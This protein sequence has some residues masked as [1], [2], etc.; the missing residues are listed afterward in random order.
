MLTTPRSVAS[1]IG[2][3][4]Q[5][6]S[7]VS[8]CIVDVGS[9]MMSNWLQLNTLKPELVDSTR[10][11]TTR[12][13][14]AWIPFNLS[15]LFGIHLHSDQSNH[16]NCIKMFAV[17]R[18]ICSISRSVIWSVLQS[19]HWCCCFLTMTANASLRFT[20]SALLEWH[21]SVLNA[22][23]RSTSV[24]LSARTCAVI[25]LRKTSTC[26]WRCVTAATM[27]LIVSSTLHSTSG[28][29][30]L[31]CKTAFYRWWRYHRHWQSFGDVWRLLNCLIGLC[32]LFIHLN[33]L[34]WR[35]ST[36]HVCRSLGE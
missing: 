24:S 7:R 34:N 9:W 25:P 15:N 14:W 11:Q 32:F 36:V 2:D 16:T 19:L 23:A 20:V 6:L 10:F 35:G 27:A 1:V 4:T 26:G 30:L 29:L 22:S 21:Q 8:A 33:A 13:W 17:L 31:E 28:F 5:F 3:S 12:W 18:Q